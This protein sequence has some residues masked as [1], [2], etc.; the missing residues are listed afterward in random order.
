MSTFCSNPVVSQ[1]TCVASFIVVWLLLHESRRAS[2]LEW[3]LNGKMF[4]GRWHIKP[5]CAGSEVLTTEPAIRHP[6]QGGEI[7]YRVRMT[8]VL[9]RQLLKPAK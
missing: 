1:F 9:E 8:D 5:L 3:E 6:F 2:G 4:L 7:W